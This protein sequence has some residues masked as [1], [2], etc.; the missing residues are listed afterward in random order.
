VGIAAR[1]T[2]TRD[3]AVE[4]ATLADEAAL[5]GAATLADEAALVGAASLAVDREA[6]EADALEQARA[7]VVHE[8][9][10]P[11]QRSIDASEA[12]QLDQSAEVVADHER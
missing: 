11:L 9:R 4:D 8:V 1:M 12:D 6:P 7:V 10:P 3:R 2:P 5:V